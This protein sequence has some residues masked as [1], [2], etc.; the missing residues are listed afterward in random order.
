LTVGGWLDL[1]GT[2][3]TCLP[4]NLT[5]GGLLDF[6]GTEVNEEEKNKE[7]GDMERHVAEVQNR[8]EEYKKALD[9]SNPKLAIPFAPKDGEERYFSCFGNYY[10]TTEEGSLAYEKYKAEAEL[11]MLCDG[12]TKKDGEEIWSPLWD[13]EEKKWNV[14]Y[15]RVRTICPY[16]FASKE[17]CRS[18]I[19][20]LGDRKL[21]LI[22]N[23]PL[24]S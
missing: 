6:R 24:E 15:W 2:E 10:H 9:E 11:L 7:K 4:D 13:R 23:I 17:A 16:S 18:A 20:K 21:R 22:F 5:V 12:F 1:Y 19:D 14:D 3:I 8:I